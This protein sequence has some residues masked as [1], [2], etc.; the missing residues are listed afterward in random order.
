MTHMP[1]LAEVEVNRLSILR[2]I[3]GGQF[4]CPKLLRDDILVLH[5]FDLRP[6]SMTGMRVQGLE[7]RGKYLILFLQSVDGEDFLLIIHFRMTGNLRYSQTLDLDPSYLK[8]A[9]IIFPIIDRFDQEAYLIW[10]DIRRFGTLELVRSSDY[11]SL[12]HSMERLGP[13]PLGPDLTADYLYKMAKRHSLLAL[14]AFLLN[15]QIVAGLGNIYVNEVLF[16]CKLNPVMKAGSLSRHDTAC[17][18]AQL[19]F[20][21]RRSIRLGGTSFRN[22][23]DSDGKTGGNQRMLKVYGRSGLPC[24][25]CGHLLETLRINGRSCVYCPLCQ[26]KKGKKTM[27]L[28]ASGY[29]KPKNET[30]SSIQAFR[31]DAKHGFTNTKRSFPAL[32]N[33]SYI[34]ADPDQEKLLGVMEAAEGRAISIDLIQ[35]DREPITATITGRGPCHLCHWDEYLVTANYGSGSLS[36]LRRYPDKLVLIAELRHHGSGPNT[37]RQAEAHAHFVE[38]SPDGLYLQ[39]VDLGCDR[40]FSY[41][42]EDLKSALLLAEQSEGGPGLLSIQAKHEAILPGGTGPRHL[43]Y[44]PD[45]KTCYVAGELSAELLVYRYNS[46]EMTLEQKIDIASPDTRAAS[47][48][49]SPSAIRLSHDGRHILI[50]VRAS[51][52]LWSFARGDDGLLTYADHKY[53]GAAWPRDFHVLADNRSIIVACERADRLVALEIDAKTGQLSQTGHTI[54]MIAPSCILPM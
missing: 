18:A 47:E 51:D 6:D 8:H 45:G 12:N 28:Y 38:L 30:E 42:L 4:L 1:E 37:E 31:Y 36:F 50:A 26:T 34:R 25:R 2:H 17:L 40:V 41:D 46:G 27:I 5:G 54:D 13:E 43:I 15:Q 21:L 29:A 23:M 52:C 22:Y 10:H 44:S 24:V 53:V 33:V 19:V 35:A 16:A 11:P 7:R 48:A 20:L 49:A 9:H 3:E 39:A 14:P 32:P